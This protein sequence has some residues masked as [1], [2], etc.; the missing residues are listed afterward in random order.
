MGP[1]NKV[2]KPRRQWKS[3]RWGRLG[4]RIYRAGNGEIERPRGGFLEA[5]REFRI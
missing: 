2:P 3:K 5:P 4:V 1:R